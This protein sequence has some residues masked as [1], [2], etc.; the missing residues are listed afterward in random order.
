M[1]NTIV[2]S[3]PTSNSLGSRTLTVLLVTA[4]SAIA[5]TRGTEPKT[6]REAFHVTDKATLTATFLSYI[7]SRDVI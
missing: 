5:Y 3:D 7:Y 1:Q 4:L 6:G 2:L